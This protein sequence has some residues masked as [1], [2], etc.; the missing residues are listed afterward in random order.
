MKISKKNE[1]YLVLEDLDP[2]TKQELTEK[3]EA[4]EIDDIVALANGEY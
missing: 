2:S 4:D 3:Q 1:V